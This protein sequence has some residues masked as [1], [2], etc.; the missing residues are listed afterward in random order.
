MNVSFY[1]FL[2]SIWP[3]VSELYDHSIVILMRK[4]L[5]GLTEQEDNRFN[6]DW[7]TT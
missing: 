5:A 1:S 6:P 4:P 3:R 2:V 7:G